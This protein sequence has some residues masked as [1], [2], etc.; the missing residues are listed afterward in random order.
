MAKRPLLTPDLVVILSGVSAAL[1]VGKLPPALP[2]LRDA[3]GITLLEAGFLLSLVQFAGMTLGLALGLAADGLGLRRSMLAGLTL[4]AA[5]SALGGW[6]RDASDLLWLRAAEGFGF[7]LVSLPAPSLIRQLVPQEQLSLRLGLWGAYM[8]LGTALALFCG[9]WVMAAMGWPGWWWSLAAVSGGMA[10]WVA[11]AVPSEAARRA[12]APRSH[13]GVGHAWWGRM[14]LT[15]T[16]SG[17]WLVALTFA[18]YA[19]QWLAV[20]GFLPSVYDQAGISGTL[21]GTLT[22]LAALCNVAGNVGSGRLVHRGVRPAHLL[23][24]AF[25]AM[26]LG[27]LIAFA[28]PEDRPVLR[29]L[30][31]LMFSGFG[32]MIPATLF[33]LAVRFAPGEQTV[34][35]TV[36]WVQQFAALGQFAGAPLVA[37]V[38]GAAG[39]WHWTWVVTGAACLA[40][41]LLVSR[42]PLERG[43]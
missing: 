31:V 25:A 39:G 30:G 8:P 10:L 14:K 24:A 19:A 3:L 34:S 33:M 27:T 1:H 5:A 28:L 20:I 37:W 35:T 7:L 17:P 22:A 12:A 2:V 43:R 32:G 4:L 16:T 11:F 13:A 23:Y 18:M 21:A 36:G 41:A 29:Y 40:G 38:A 6:A 15:L 9:P 26:A 42:M